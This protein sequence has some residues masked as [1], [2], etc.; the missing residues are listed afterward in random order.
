VIQAPKPP[1]PTVVTGVVQSL[2]PETGDLTSFV[3]QPP[4][5]GKGAAPAAVTVT[6]TADTL[7]LLG[8]AAGTA[9]DVKVGV[10]VTAKLTGFADNAGTATQVSIRVPPPPMPTLV[11]GV[12]T[13]LTPETGDLQSFVVQPPTP[14]HGTA[15]APVTVTVNADTTYFV[16]KTAGTAADLTVGAKVAAR[17]IGFADNAGTALRVR[18][19]PAKP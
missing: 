3:V 5:H 14:R 1:R 13:S 7:Y 8:D 11:M 19:A 17:L 15:P 10:V 12:V 2:T 4:T 16:G 9:A 18:I 6:V